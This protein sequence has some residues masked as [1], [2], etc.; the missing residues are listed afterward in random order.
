MIDFPLNPTHGN[1]YTYLDIQYTFYKPTTAEGYWRV[2]TPAS[3]GV[4][5]PTEI[6]EGTDN[7]KYVTPQGLDSSEYV[8]EDKTSGETVLDYA[9]SERLKASNAG[10]EITG[11]LLLD[12]DVE[13]DGS[14]VPIVIEHGTN[15][16]AG[17]FRRWSDGTVEQ[18][19][20][21]SGSSGSSIKLGIAYL[22]VFNGCVASLRSQGANGDSAGIVQSGL[23]HFKIYHSG[24]ASTNLNYWVTGK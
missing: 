2:A 16:H 4:A 3:V 5:T 14:V 15:N 20:S 24:G 22:S 21:V 6:N 8:R 23:T 9:G 7:A 13:K 18:W 10:V 19:G 11:K 12:G 1:T 17:G